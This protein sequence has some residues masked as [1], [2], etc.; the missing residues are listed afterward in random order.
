MTPLPA[1]R[2]E[3]SASG[4]RVATCGIVNLSV[5]IVNYRS[6]DDLARCLASLRYLADLKQPTTEIIVVDNQSGDGRLPAFAAEHSGVRFVE[7]SG[8]YGFAHACNRGA[9]E[10]RGTELLFLNPDTRDPG[11]V[12]PLYL[13]VKQTHPDAAVLTV[14]QTDERGRPQRIFGLFPTA[15][16]LL[17]PVRALLRILL[18]ETHP[19]PRRTKAH[20]L[21]V[22]WVSGSALM[23]SRAHLGRLGGWCEDFWMYSEDTDLCR[24]AANAGLAVVYCG[25]ATLVH[26]HGGATRSNPETAA[27]TR[28]EAVISKHLYARRHL[29]ALHAGV[30]H[31]LVVITRFLPL[32]APA[33]IAAIWRN[34]PDVV[35]VR[36]SM[37]HQLRVH[38]VRIIAKHNWLS[39]RSANTRP[40]S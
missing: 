20:T 35:K 24:R 38:Y 3:F 5:I 36:A 10:A 37:F 26:R 16:T 2:K 7:N 19:D 1:P 11:G 34:A 23:I 4:T 17:G 25:D 30:F 29:G 14:R 8:N 32:A 22:D 39:P 33:L 15:G 6:W 27:L 18:P 28:T 12:V 31:L 40:V 21:R 13:A 9:R